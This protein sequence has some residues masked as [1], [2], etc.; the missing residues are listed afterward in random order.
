MPDSEVMEIMVFLLFVAALVGMAFLVRR[1]LFG[2]THTKA[3]IE[4]EKKRQAHP[5]IQSGRF[6]RLYTMPYSEDLNVKNICA[7]C[8]EHF[9]AY[10]C[11]VLGNRVSISETRNGLSHETRELYITHLK[12][13]NISAVELVDPHE[14]VSNGRYGQFNTRSSLNDKGFSK[15]IREMILHFQQK[16]VSQK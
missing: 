1:F 5:D 10:H 3:I 13:H 16:A 15:D 9:P 7:Y 2:D 14:L 11:T 12:G 8:D 6:T 4:A